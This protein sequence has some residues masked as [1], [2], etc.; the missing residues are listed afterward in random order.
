MQTVEV[1]RLCLEYFGVGLLPFSYVG[2][3][4]GL[5]VHTTNGLRGRIQGFVWKAL[6]T[7]LWIGLMIVNLVKTAAL[8]QME[9]RGIYRMDT[10]Y[11]MSD[12]VTDAA[13]MAGLYLFIAVLEIWLGVMRRGER[14]IDEVEDVDAQGLRK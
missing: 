12:W 14:V 8:V 5:V 1:V 10:K 9:K 13:V 3:V 4:F 6:N 2:L 11:P 7:L